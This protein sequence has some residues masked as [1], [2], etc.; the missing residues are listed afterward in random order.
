V[1]PVSS[2]SPRQPPVSVPRDSMKSLNL[3]MSDL[4][5]IL[6][7]FRAAPAFSVTVSGAHSKWTFTLV[8]VASR[9]V[10]LMM[11]AWDLP[12]VLRQAIRSSGS[13]S[14]ISVSNSRF[15]P[16]TFVTQ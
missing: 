15:T 8:W 7:I 14:T 12:S 3:R 5:C 10:N 4:T 2:T 11:P 16:P 13:W 1:G 6:S 9:G